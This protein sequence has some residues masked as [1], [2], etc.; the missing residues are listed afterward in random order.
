MARP[1][2]WR[3]ERVG[4]VLVTL[5]AAT[6]VLFPLL[7]RFE[8]WATSGS[9]VDR[10][11]MYLAPLL[12]LALVM[13]PG[14]IDRRTSLAVA[15]GVGATLFTAPLTHNYLEQPAIFGTQT[16]IYDIAP[17]FAHHQKFGLVFVALPLMLAGVFAL[18]A[19]KRSTT[20]LAV[21]V[22]IVAGVMVTQSWTSQSLE[23]SA[24]D[25]GRYTAVPRQVDWV[26][27]HADGPVALLSVAKP[28]P[29]RPN[30]DL[31]TEFFNRKVKYMYSTLP[32]GNGACNVDLKPSGALKQGTDY[33]RDFP[34]N[35]VILDGPIR[36]TLW[37]QR[38]LAT[39]PHNGTLV[40]IPV[41]APRVQSIVSPPCSSVGCTGQ[42]QLAVYLDEPA[43]VAI[44]F[45][46]TPTAHRIETG[47]GVRTLPA[48]QPATLNFKL[49]KGAQ[50]VNFPVDWQSPA[51]APDLRAV[52]MR[53]GG[54][55]YRLY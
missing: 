7:G 17:F 20:G 55:S 14:R 42:L 44:T 39:T 35:W 13:A 18:S 6:V 3:D 11:A 33:C 29:W 23:I 46:G 47:A 52:V 50:S 15:V 8:A 10:Y 4:P 38:T 41:G 43:T 21:A 25:S 12:F 2:N 34:R 1:A 30:I 27:R 22:A 28:Q 37:G 9:P 45:S 32:V 16:R 19:R 40:R 51:G 49:P 5:L 26:D 31:Y 48:G 54:K 36:M 24:I 53:S